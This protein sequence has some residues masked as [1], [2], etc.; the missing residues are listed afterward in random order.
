MSRKFKF[1]LNLITVAALL[2][3]LVIVRK[4]IADAFKK[5]PDLNLVALAMIIPIQ[6]LS[7]YAAAKRYQVTLRA[8][9]EEVPVPFLYKV[10][11][12]MNLVNQ[13]FPSGGV[14]GFSYLSL[15][16]K[17][18]GVPTAKS[19]LTQVIFYSLTF[20]GFIVYLT[21]A[22]LLLAVV[23]Q[24]SRL[25]VLISATLISLV[26]FGAIVAVYIISDEKRITSFTAF[27]PK[28][29]NRIIGQFRKS[30]VDTIDIGRIE[31]LFAALHKDYVLIAQNLRKL[32]TPLKWSLLFLWC[33]MATIYSVYVAFGHWV[34]PGAL[35][36]AYA[37]ANIAGLISILPGGVG[38]Y[39]S[40]MTG[41]MASAGVDGGLAFSVTVV[42]RILNM[43]LFLPIGYWFYSRALRLHEIEPSQAPHIGTM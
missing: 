19:T 8:L 10:G 21:V 33:E 11:L 27:L 1:W 17:S 3:L 14:S 16:L 12:E 42:Y 4:Q 28:I 6:L 30:K 43:M 13:V 26:V 2:V 34:N 40:L 5:I 32:T 20:G 18:R 23:G 9:G 7:Y 31:H 39:E 25:T 37:V 22:M 36:I 29:A 38:V 24:A 41:V 15:R 35:I